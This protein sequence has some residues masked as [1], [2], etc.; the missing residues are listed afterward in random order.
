[1]IRQLLLLM[2]EGLYRPRISAER[3]LSANYGVDVGVMFLVLAY[4][5]QAILQIVLPGARD[6]PDGVDRIPIAVH[7]LNILLQAALVGMLSMLIYGGGRAFGGTGTKR[8]AFMIV[9]WHTLVTTLLAPIFLI[10]VAHIVSGEVPSTL[11][12]LMAA[13][14]MLWL[15]VLAVY[16][17]ALHGF[18]NAWGTMGVMFAVVFLLSSVFVNMMPAP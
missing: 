1:M 12:F 9:S 5:I 7:L 10:G 13:A 6:L 18:R 15:W 8:Q 16:M 14:G 3:I 4:L 2:A 17:A 11:L